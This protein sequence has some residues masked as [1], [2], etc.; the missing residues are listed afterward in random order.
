M[1]PWEVVVG[2][3]TTSV[4]LGTAIEEVL[5]K[6]NEEEERVGRASL[7]V[8]TEEVVGTAVAGGV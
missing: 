3:T 2:T 1:G 6:T 7:V 4:V 8:M 5:E